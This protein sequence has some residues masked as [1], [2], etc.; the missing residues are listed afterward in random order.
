MECLQLFQKSNNFPRELERIEWIIFSLVMRRIY[1]FRPGTCA[2]EMA[3]NSAKSATVTSQIWQSPGKKSS[4]C[5]KKCISSHDSIQGTIVFQKVDGRLKWL[6]ALLNLP[7]TLFPNFCRIADGQYFDR[8]GTYIESA[9][10][11]H[12]KAGCLV[13]RLKSIHTHFVAH[14]W[15]CR[16]LYWLHLFFVL[17]GTIWT[18]LRCFISQINLISLALVK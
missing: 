1:F 11:Q 3:R 17:L 14:T 9:C 13:K 2:S 6:T 4:K 15:R 8:L 7:H 16:L 18:E 5:R 12:A 10:S